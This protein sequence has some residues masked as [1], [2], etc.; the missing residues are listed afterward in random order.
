MKNVKPV[1]A[2]AWVSAAASPDADAAPNSG[3][4]AASPDADA[5]L[6]AGDAPLNA[7]AGDAPNAGAGGCD[8]GDA[9]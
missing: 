9:D 5:T 3:D 7:G 2:C 8:G 1:G 6:G 4:A